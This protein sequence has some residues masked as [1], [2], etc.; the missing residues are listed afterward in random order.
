MTIPDGAQVADLEGMSLHIDNTQGDYNSFFIW[1]WLDKGDD[2]HYGGHYWKVIERDGVSSTITMPIIPPET[3]L[4][5]ASITEDDPTVESWSV[6]AYSS[7]VERGEK[8][9][10]FLGSRYS[11]F[12]FM[13]PSTQRQMKVAPSDAHKALL[14]RELGGRPGLEPLDPAEGAPLWMG[15]L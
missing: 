9:D 2:H 10:H 1:E 11:D 3:G 4:R 15:A 7:V 5:W 14:T 12:E 6:W 8:E 13:A